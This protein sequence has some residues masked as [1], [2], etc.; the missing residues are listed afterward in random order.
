M[1]GTTET[2]TYAPASGQVTRLGNVLPAW[3]PGLLEDQLGGIYKHGGGHNGV[4]TDVWEYLP[5]GGT[6][7][8]RGH[9]FGGHATTPT[10]G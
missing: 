2:Y 1:G 8:T 10:S 9:G 7:W 6:T 4:V 5:Q 3:Y